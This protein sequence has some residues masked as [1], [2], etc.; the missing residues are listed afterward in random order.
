[1]AAWCVL[2]SEI[3][4]SVWSL[5][6]AAL[7]ITG[8]DSFGPRYSYLRVDGRGFNSTLGEFGGF[9]VESEPSGVEKV[10]AGQ[11]CGAQFIDFRPQF[12][13]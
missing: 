4:R 6:S 13:L 3:S 8:Y 12:W 10:I 2:S 5:L 7:I 9:W 11:N 1:M